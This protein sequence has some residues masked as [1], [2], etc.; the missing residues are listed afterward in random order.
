MA[1]VAEEHGPDFTG[2]VNGSED[3]Q[4]MVDRPVRIDTEVDP[5][6]VFE[7]PPIGCE[8]DLALAPRQAAGDRAA[9][10]ARATFSIASVNSRV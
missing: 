10:A 4:A 2:G 6:A 8:A 1:C 3:G 9:K 7:D 5:S